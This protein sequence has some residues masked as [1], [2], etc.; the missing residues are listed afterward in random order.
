MPE[1]PAESTI[2]LDRELQALRAYR[3]AFDHHA[4]V[5]VTDRSGRIIRVNDL[6]CQIS[7]YSREELIGQNHRILNSGFHPKRFW[8]EAWRTI[9]HGQVW[10][11]EVCNRAKDG[12]LYWVDTTIVPIADDSG[13]IVE[14]VAIRADITSRKHAE[15]ALR[16]AK[17]AADA[18]NRAKSE[19]L[20]NMSH[21]IRTPMNG[22]P[23]LCRP[24]ARYRWLIGAS[25]ASTCDMVR[26]NG[27]HLLA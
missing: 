10:H 3:A 12:T 1:S 9:A 24:A 20:A 22:H 14:H 23:R 21:E 11:G 15:E 2:G 19:F 27:E 13:R 8:V 4:I 17:N 5:A 18:A 25:S 6:F 7:K 16:A 26:R